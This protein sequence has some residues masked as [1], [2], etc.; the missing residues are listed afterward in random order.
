[1]ELKWDFIA[2]Q[3]S[4]QDVI[5]DGVLQRFVSPREPYDFIIHVAWTP[6]SAVFEKRTSKWVAGVSVCGASPSVSCIPQAWPLT[7]LLFPG[8]IGS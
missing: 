1:M 3:S 2:L 5:H 7:A 6:T 4:R 8:I